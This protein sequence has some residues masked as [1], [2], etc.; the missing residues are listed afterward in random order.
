MR[1]LGVPDADCDDAVQDVFLIVHRRLADFRPDAPIKHWLFRITSRVARDH[2][3]S[4]RRKDPK[5]HGLTPIAPDEEIVDVEQKSPVESAERSAAA[6][7]I[8]DLLQ[9]LE[10][11]KREVFILAD[12]EQ[13]TAPEIAE[14]LEIPLNTVYSRLRRARSDFESALTR[15]RAR[16]NGETP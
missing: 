1:R 16:E 12:L 8:R 13:M 10:E 14:V 4:R 5:Q 2:R 6:R 15:H 3:R 11:T 9:E 7:L